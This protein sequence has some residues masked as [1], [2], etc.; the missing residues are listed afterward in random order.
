MGEERVTLRSHVWNTQLLILPTA[1]NL[2]ISL[3]NEILKARCATASDTYVHVFL[4]G[5]PV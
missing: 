3:E 1:T 5:R 4:N 2:I